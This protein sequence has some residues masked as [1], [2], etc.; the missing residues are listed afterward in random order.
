M[1]KATGSMKE[2]LISIL[3]QENF[4]P[5]EKVKSVKEIYNKLDVQY[6]STRLMNEFYQKGIAELDSV[7]VSPERK[8]QLYALASSLLSRDN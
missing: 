7:S 2:D 5:Q 3:E 8:E 6:D 1:Q 4:D